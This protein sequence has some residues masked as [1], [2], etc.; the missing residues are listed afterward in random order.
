ME[1]RVRKL[2][3]IENRL[4]NQG[5]KYI[6]G[7]DEVGRG[8]IAGPVVAGCVILPDKIP[9]E[10]WEVDDSKKLSPLKREILAKLI[11]KYALDWSI[12]IVSSDI[13]DKINI[14]NATKLAMKK[15]IFKLKR[16]PDILLI[17][18]VKLD[19]IRIKQISIIHGDS[20][21][22]SIASASII[23]KVVRDKIMKVLGGKFFPEYFFSSNKGY[24]T[25][26]HVEAIKKFGRSKI[27]RLTFKIKS[28]NE[29]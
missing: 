29:Y 3:K 14:L 28:L 4:K 9:C 6:A 17:D 26:H 20:L 18:A 25:K 11:K 27:H 10:L 24:P 22:L 13:I 23:A 2:L 12:G 16:K 5:F 15:A 7:L 1:E 21:S 8:A 19:D